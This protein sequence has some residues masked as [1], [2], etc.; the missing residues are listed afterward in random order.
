MRIKATL[1]VRLGRY[2]FNNLILDI[3]QKASYLFKDPQEK[4]DLSAHKTKEMFKT[5]IAEKKDI[6]ELIAASVA[7]AEKKAIV[8]ELKGT[9]VKTFDK[10]KKSYY[11]NSNFHI[12]YDPYHKRYYTFTWIWDAHTNIFPS[13]VTMTYDPQ[14]YQTSALHHIT[15][16]PTKSI[17]SFSLEDYATKLIEEILLL[18]KTRFYLPFRLRN[19]D[20]LYGWSLSDV[21]N[22]KGML[23]AANEE[24]KK[25]IASQKAKLQQRLSKVAATPK[26]QTKNPDFKPLLNKD[27]TEIKKE[28][29]FAMDGSLKTLKIISEA[30]KAKEGII[31]QALNEVQ[32]ELISTSGVYPYINL[33]LFWTKHADILINYQDKELS[34]ILY[35]ESLLY[36]I[37]S[38]EVNS[39]ENIRK[40][41]ILQSFSLLCWR[42]VINGWETFGKTSQRQFKWLQL[43]IQ[44]TG[45]YKG[46]ET[47]ESLDLSSES[48]NKEELSPLVYFYLKYAHFPDS[49]VPE[50]PLKDYQIQS[51]RPA[52][53]FDNNEDKGPVNVTKRSQV[54]KIR[55]NSFVEP[56][57]RLLI[58]D[59]GYLEHIKPYANQFEDLYNSYFVSENQQSLKVDKPKE[60]KKEAEK[61][62][63]KVKPKDSIIDK[64]KAK[65][66]KTKTA[67][68]EKKETPLKLEKEAA[69]KEEKKAEEG[70]E[71]IRKFSVDK[72][73]LTAH[74]DSSKKLL[75][76]FEKALYEV[77][78][79]PTNENVLLWRVFTKLLWDSWNEFE[80][81]ED[82]EVE[83]KYLIVHLERV[84]AFLERVIDYYSQRASEILE[85]T[86]NVGAKIVEYITTL[87]SSVSNLTYQSSITKNFGCEDI[88]YTLIK[89]S[90]KLKK[91]LEFQDDK[92]AR[93]NILNHLITHND[94]GI[95]YLNEKVIETNHPYERSRVINF[96]PLVFPGAIAISVEFDR[97]CQSDVSHDFLSLF[98]G[99][100][101]TYSNVGYFMNHREAIGTSFRISGKPNLK[102]PLVMLGN[103]LQIDFAPSGQVK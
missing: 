94:E 83:W 101:S 10:N 18:Q 35:I 57:G 33:L 103:C 92:G 99:Y 63:E 85:K 17:A 4:F 75:E 51:V 37:L 29:A 93:T 89:I 64:I 88:A 61:E 34:E 41:S 84:L 82:G 98:S 87:V 9:F 24:E 55:E 80:K 97:R 71:K 48:I 52:D 56:Y 15:L 13:L 20:Y 26:D 91:F 60:E 90:A 23:G 72:E 102:K 95:D 45:K 73:I 67:K 38:H 31:Y 16:T 6:K 46:V 5:A 40:Y 65:G 8:V 11:S 39:A 54:I 12:C 77:A 36:N 53:V 1:T 86:P 59:I 2:R 19:W 68:E 70:S 44:S 47:A 3:T 49:I 14:R 69:K 32:L 58:E 78:N 28:Y 76:S 62:A 81:I 66:K 27:L 22:R 7:K 30:L 43:I 100:D 21:Q 50:F 79:H 25:K 42:I 74:E 96:D